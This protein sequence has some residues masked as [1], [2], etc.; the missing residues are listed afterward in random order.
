MNRD[1]G[2]YHL[3][4]IFDE[5]LISPLRKSPKGKEKINWQLQDRHRYSY[6]RQSPVT[7]HLSSSVDNDNSGYRNVHKVSATLWISIKNNSLR[8]ESYKKNRTQTC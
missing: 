3:S 4:H 5:L 6:Q 7:H 8:D 2:Q 1:E